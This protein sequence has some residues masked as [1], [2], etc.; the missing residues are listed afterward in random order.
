MAT[1]DIAASQHTNISASILSQDMEIPLERDDQAAQ[2]FDILP[3]FLQAAQLPAHTCADVSLHLRKNNRLAVLR[4]H[5]EAIVNRLLRITSITFQNTSP[6]VHSYLAAPNN[7]CRVVIHVMASGATPDEIINDLESYQADILHARRMG[8]TGSAIN[9]FIGTHVPYTVY[10]RRIEFRCR[11][12][13]PRAHHC[14]SCVGYGH[15]TLACPGNQRRC[16]TCSTTLARPDEPHP[17]TPW[18]ALLQL[19]V[20][21]SN[22]ALGPE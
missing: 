4:T 2:P 9:T 16:P 5:H 20:W 15:R 21:F 7:S 22:R 19:A 3:A 12:H 10:Y 1:A 13:K 14:N 11:P 8:T 17:C 18:F 6:P